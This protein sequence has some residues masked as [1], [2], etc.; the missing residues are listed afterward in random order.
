MMKF[1]LR[2]VFYTIIIGCLLWLGKVLMKLGESHNEYQAL[3]QADENDFEKKVHEF[4][5]T[6]QDFFA[7]LE[8]RIHLEHENSIEISAVLDTLI[9]KSKIELCWLKLT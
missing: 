8:E 7:K 3:K 2:L 1:G 5:E 4:E 6:N 9:E